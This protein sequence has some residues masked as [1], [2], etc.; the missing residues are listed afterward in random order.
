MKVALL[1]DFI[2]EEVVDNTGK[3]LGVLSCYWEAED[4]LLFLGVKP[5]SDEQ[6]HVVP[7]IG[8]SIDEPHSIIK[9]GFPAALVRT[10]PVFDC[11]R[12]MRPRLEESANEHFSVSSLDAEE[13]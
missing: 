6:V 5:S 1:E 9:L 2:D 11:D 7:G 8:A 3:T 10:A 4:G 13:G 12:E